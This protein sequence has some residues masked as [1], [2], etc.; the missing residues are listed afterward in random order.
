MKNIL[1]PTDFSIRS[2]EL[3]KAAVHANINE[4]MNI[5]LFH[6]FKMSDNI[7]ELMMLSRR[8]KD[9][10]HISDEFRAVCAQL[11]DRYPARINS[12]KVEC[13]YGSTLAVFKNY[14]Y[15]NDISLIVYDEQ[16]RFEKVNKS[17][18]DPLN[19]IKKSGCELLPLTINTEKV[20]VGN[21]LQSELYKPTR[22][23]AHC[24]LPT[25]N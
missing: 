17:S 3:V 5:L 19:I 12:I 10:E 20:T 16:Y 4:R 2:L 8:M 24:P 25:A 23:T 21:L 15:G 9:Y 22:L 18:I 11:Q 14:L 6:C 1:I 13:F 7:Q